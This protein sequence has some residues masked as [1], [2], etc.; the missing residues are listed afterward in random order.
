MGEDDRT[1]A[2]DP[3]DLI[4]ADREIAAFHGTPEVGAI[5]DVDADALGR[6]AAD[7]VAARIG[8]E[9][10]DVVRVQ[11]ALLGERLAAGAQLDGPV[12]GGI[13]RQLAEQL[14]RLPDQIVLARRDAAHD[15][16]CL[17][18]GRRRRLLALLDAGINDDREGRHHRYQDQDQQTD[19]QAW[20]QRLEH[21]GSGKRRHSAGA[22]ADYIGW[23]RVFPCAISVSGNIPAAGSGGRPCRSRARL[24]RGLTWPSASKTSNSRH[25][26]ARSG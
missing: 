21:G 10:I 9:E 17:L 4:V 16:Q 1:L 7:D 2:G 8:G 26:E 6:G 15:G 3:A 13:A 25:G 18:L 22:G 12:Q 24:Q 20:Q 11:A 19:M 23:T 14:V 5:V